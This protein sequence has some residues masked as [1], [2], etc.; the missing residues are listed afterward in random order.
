MCHCILLVGMKLIGIV[1]HASLS[2]VGIPNRLDRA[3]GKFRSQ[4][5]CEMSRER[6]R[7]T[8]CCEA[9]R[10]IHRVT[11]DD[12]E[13]FRYAREGIDLCQANVVLSE[14]SSSVLYGSCRCRIGFE[15]NPNGFCILS[16]WIRNR[17]GA[18]EG[19]LF[20]SVIFLVSVDIRFHETSGEDIVLRS[21][22]PHGIHPCS[23]AAAVCSPIKVWDSASFESIRRLRT[24][25]S[26]PGE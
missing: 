11:F 18:G 15:I 13:I 21:S 14:G 8:F 20:C 12:E 5:S 23:G 19:K 22:A 7:S 17:V 6:H 1:R 25:N 2:N 24:D 26:A 9:R 16:S 4:M 10:L 3:I